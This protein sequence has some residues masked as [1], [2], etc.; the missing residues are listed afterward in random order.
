MVFLLLGL[1]SNSCLHGAPVLPEQMELQEQPSMLC[2]S[3]TALL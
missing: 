1:V 2:D 3:A